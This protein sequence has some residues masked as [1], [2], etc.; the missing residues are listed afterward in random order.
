LSLQLTKYFLTFCTIGLISAFAGSLMYVLCEYISGNRF[1][2]YIVTIA[3]ALGTLCMPYSIVFYG[4]QLAAALLFAGFF[5]IFGIKVNPAAPR[6]SHLFMIG[7]LLGFALVTEYTTLIIVLPLVFYYLFVMWKGQSSLGISTVVL[8][9]LGG[10]IPLSIMF[11]Y[12]TICFGG[13]LSLSYGFVSNPNFSMYVTKGLF[14]I[15]WP[16]LDVLYYMTMFPAQGLFWQSPVLLLAFIGIYWMFRV[17]KYRVEAILVSLVFCSFLLVNSGYFMWWGGWAFGI[18]GIIPALPFLCLPLVF[19][20]R[21]LHFLAIIL[22]IVSVSQM[23]IVA[24]SNVQVPD[25]FIA[26]LGKQGYFDYST[27]YSFC[28]NQLIHGQYAYNLGRA[29]LGL[30]NQFSL[31]PVILLNLMMLG[32]FALYKLVSRGSSLER[33]SSTLV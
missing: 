19:I 26:N 3:I 10:L 16:R 22:T 18:R 24:A 9:A 28:L 6:K 23:L 13:P 11:A 29:L 32:Y 20:P 4:H 33:A 31:L 1:W 21:R 5:L 12:N 27:I 30:K 17:S 15:G 8:P 14:G 25:G 2:T 7:F